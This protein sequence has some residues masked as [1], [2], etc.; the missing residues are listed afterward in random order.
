MGS[1]VASGDDRA[2]KATSDALMHPLWCDV[3]IATAKAVLIS[4]MGNESLSLNEV[5]QI[6]SHVTSTHRLHKQSFTTVDRYTDFLL[7]HRLHMRCIQM[8][9]LSLVQRK[10]CFY[11]IFYHK[12]INV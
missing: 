7:K 8:L 6:T 12:Q 3:D 11:F 4:V 1:G 5:E 10:I 9:Q 2:S